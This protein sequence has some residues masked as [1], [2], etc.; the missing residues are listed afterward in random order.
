[1]TSTGECT[2]SYDHGLRLLGL[3]PILTIRSLIAR[4]IKSGRR[5]SVSYSP[6]SL[7]Q[8]IV[9]KNALA[10]EIYSRTFDWIVSKI[11][12]LLTQHVDLS[13]KVNY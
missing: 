13:G 9:N 4:S 12:T 1:L 3:D 7:E 8:A 6:F 5:G 2:S 11:N 10:K